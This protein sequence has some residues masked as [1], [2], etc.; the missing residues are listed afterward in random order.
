MGKDFVVLGL[1]ILATIAK[2]I[3]VVKSKVKYIWQEVIKVNCV[4]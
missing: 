1:L 3:P 4:R 2:N